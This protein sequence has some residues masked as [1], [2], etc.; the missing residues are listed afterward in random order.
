M[1]TPLTAPPASH[2]PIVESSRG[3]LAAAPPRA[4]AAALVL[5]AL[6]AAATYCN[7]LRGTFLYD[8]Y[9]YIVENPQVQQPT[10]RRLFGEPLTADSPQLGLYR[11]L[12]VSTY[13]LQARGRGEEAPTWEFHAF[14]VALHAGVALLLYLLALRLG[15]APAAAL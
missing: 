2:A 5:L 8:D 15:L 14:N 4:S 12:V 10:L 6:L 11:P 3:P 1:P 13:A 7:A 9:P